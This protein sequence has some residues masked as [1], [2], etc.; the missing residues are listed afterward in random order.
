MYKVMQI[1]KYIVDNDRV[2]LMMNDN[3]CKM[4]EK[5]IA[6]KEKEETK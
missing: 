5:R 1:S 6:N 2:S 3:E 4:L